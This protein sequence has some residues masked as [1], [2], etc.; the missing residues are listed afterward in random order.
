MTFHSFSDFFWQ[1]LRIIANYSSRIFGEMI[2]LNIV[3]KTLM[4]L[5]DDVEFGSGV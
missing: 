2:D 4:E 3:D 5:L 1:V